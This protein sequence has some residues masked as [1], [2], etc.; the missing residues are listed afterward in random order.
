MSD[1]LSKRKEVNDKD[2]TFASEFDTEMM[3]LLHN[4]SIE[5][6]INWMII[7]YEADVLELIHAI[8]GDRLG[9]Y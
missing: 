9:N 1:D 5:E 8:Y 7:N 6:I 3:Y 4:Y 2:L